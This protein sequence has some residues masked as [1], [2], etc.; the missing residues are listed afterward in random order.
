[1]PKRD[2]TAYNRKY[3]EEH[4]VELRKKQKTWYEANKKLVSEKQRAY[5]QALSPE[6][7]KERRARWNA[8]HKA[9]EKRRYHA[10]RLW[11]PWLNAFRGSK[12]RATKNRVPFTLTKE[13]AEARWTGRCEVTNIE[14]ILSTKRSPYLFSPSLDRII[15]TLG[16]T[17][18]NSR[19]ILHA[20]NALKGQGTDEDMLTIA[21]AIVQH[22]KEL[23]PML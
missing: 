18:E 1:M 4:Y 23:F 6:V 3:R 19:F 12:A 5:R 9:K 22:Q 15:P 13:W 20:V 7:A 2:K 17:P 16:Y 21:K 11:L 10:T 14:F 8:A